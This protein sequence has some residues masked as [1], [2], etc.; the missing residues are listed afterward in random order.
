LPLALL[1]TEEQFPVIGFDID[2]QEVETLN[3]GG[4]YIDRIP[5]TQVQ[6]AA[7][8]GFCATAD[9]SSLTNID[10]I[11]NCVPTPLIEYR[12][13]DLSFIENAAKVIAPYLRAGQ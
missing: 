6:A 13:L 1:Y 11:I 3:S 12:E 7:S 2:Q 10:A 5:P 9:F 4:K 8:P